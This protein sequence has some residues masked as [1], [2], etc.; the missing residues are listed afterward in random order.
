MPTNLHPDCLAARQKYMEAKTPTEKTETL[1]EYIS[2][3]PRHKGTER[4]LRQLRSKLSKLEDEVEKGR[5]LR[6]GSAAKSAFHI[7]KEG[8]GQVAL[9][10][11]TT[12]G[13]SSLLKWLTNAKPEVSSHQFK[14]RTPVPGMME[15]EDIK[16]QLIEIPAIYE[17]L[18]SGK[19]LGPQIIASIRNSDAVALVIDL[20]KDPTQQMGI[21]LRELHNSGIR[22]NLQPPRIDIRRTGSGGVQIFGA[23]LYRNNLDELRE[24]LGK[25]SHNVTARL[26]QH[27]TKSEILEAIDPRI[28]Y[29]K[30]IIIA[31]KGDLPGSSQNHEVLQEKYDHSFAIIPVSAE[32]NKGKTELK[33]EIFKALEIIRVYT[34]EPREKPSE[35]PVVLRRDA[36]VADL[37]RK[38][39]KVFQEQFKY[40]KVMGPSAKF[41]MELVGLT[42]ILSDQD[43]VQVY[44]S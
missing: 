43:I 21:I 1:R 37:I 15:H 8:A 42:H 31:T 2:L 36:T 13:R 16:I 38:L 39:P 18:S 6:R 9:V 28:T 19:G 22:L 12:T 5:S 41:D 40:A 33:T 25:Y 29:K 24:I 17:D 14:T 7:K 23:G 32:T 4:L 30:A 10:G 44:L 3:V 34:K 20:S 11:L 35:K 26:Y 27:T